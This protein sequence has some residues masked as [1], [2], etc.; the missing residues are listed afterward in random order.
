MAALL[1]ALSANQRLIWQMQRLLP[2]SPI[3]C[4]AIAGR[5]MSALNLHAFQR[6]CQWL[7]DRHGSLRTTY[8]TKDS[9]PVRVVHPHQPVSVRVHDAFEW[10]DD[11]L[12]QRFDGEVHRVFDLGMGPLMRVHV[13]LGSSGQDRLLLTFHH[14][15]TDFYSLML[16][17]EDIRSLYPVACR[18]GA[19]PSAPPSTYDDFVR[20]QAQFLDSDEGERQWRF[21][22]NR[23][24]EP[25]EL[26]RLPLDHPHPGTTSYVGAT[27]QFAVGSDL[28]A[29]LRALASASSATMNAV[30]LAGFQALLH[31]WCGEP[32]FAIRTIVS[33]RSMPAFSQVVGHFANAVPVLADF[34]DDP[35]FRTAVSRSRQSVADAVEHQD[36]PIAVLAER[37]QR[38]GPVGAN[39]SSDV[40]F[41]LQTPHRFRTELRT[42]KMPQG[43]E[44]SAARSPGTRMDLGGLVVELFNPIRSVTYHA[45][46][47]EL[48]EAGG[49]VA[50]YVHYRSDLFQPSTIAGLAERYVQ[51]LDSV[52]TE[53]DERL[54]HIAGWHESQTRAGTRLSRQDQPCVPID[55]WGISVDLRDVEAA[56]REHPSVRDAA[57]ACAGPPER[58][59]AR[60]AAHLV[61]DRPDRLV[62]ERELRQYLGERVPSYLI[63]AI[64]VFSNVPERRLDGHLD[65]ALQSSGAA[66]AAV[67]SVCHR[68]RTATEGK[69]VRLWQRV[70][71]LDAI[72][73]FDNFFVLGGHSLVAAQL[74]A[75]IAAEFGRDLPL[76]ALLAAP[77]VAELAA[78]ID[79]ICGGDAGYASSEAPAPR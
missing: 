65:P 6:T 51:L 55:C 57:V 17:L 24:S 1:H 23:A 54:S 16:I 19:P 59:M 40:M 11:E 22:S 10:D 26:L 74:S 46:D 61:S 29:R 31:R 30:L 21:W 47:L 70:L 4:Q 15:A 53:P 28:T 3:Y 44:I 37:L 13:F 49:E 60:L 68:P 8:E 9:E 58:P 25:V 34:S 63:P 33:G 72:G 52:T 14:I 64:F 39:R 75:L 2:Q 7:L 18:D 50:G 71:G 43:Q 35:T 45:V 56:L 73:I 69:L 78:H 38:D 27:H 66:S 41:R 20:W 42:Q 67:N 32:R 12:Q 36:L 77:T 62:L 76:G 48:V 5:I 79:L